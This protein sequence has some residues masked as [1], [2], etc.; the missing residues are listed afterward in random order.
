M[1][2]LFSAS[3]WFLLTGLFNLD[4]SCNIRLALVGKMGILQIN[5]S[6]ILRKLTTFILQFFILGI[7]QICF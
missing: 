1:Q 7:L 3:S 6:Q 4:D 2:C 5:K